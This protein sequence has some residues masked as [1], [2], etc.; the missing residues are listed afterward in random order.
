MNKKQNFKVKP[1]IGIALGSGGARGCAHIGV[2][3]ALHE[4]NIPI[5]VIAGTSMGA[6]VGAAYAT[7]YRIEELEDMA[8]QMRWRWLLNLFDPTLPRQGIIAGNKIEKYFE[9]LTKGKEF[10]QLKKPLIVIAT[11][12]ISGEEV[13]INKGLVAKA[14]RASIAIPG[15]FS[16]IKSGKRL[17]VDGSVTTP[18]PI[19]AVMEAG[20]DIVIAVDVSSKVDQT[21]S[22][23]KIWKRLKSMSSK[24]IVRF[25]KNSQFEIINIIDNTLELCDH[26][27]E[28]SKLTTIANKHYFMLKPDVG[29]VRWYEFYRVKECIHAGEVM[30]KQVAEKLRCFLDSGKYGEE[31]EKQN[32]WGL[33]E[34]ICN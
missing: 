22:L 28:V 31:T 11:D 18:V 16:P 5:D 21:S 32:C 9:I 20:A 24:K 13:R 10:A 6:V 23:E 15:L 7:G 4:A 3:K 30:G 27:K 19:L 25:I 8:L 17:L 26:P 34:R 14:L 29:D 1:C 33:R 12:I 2:L